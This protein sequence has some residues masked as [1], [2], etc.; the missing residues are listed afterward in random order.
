MRTR[1]GR[2]VCEVVLGLALLVTD[3]CGKGGSST[4][5][6][7]QTPGDFDFGGNDPH[8]VAAFGDSITEGVLELKRRDLGLSTA[9]NY[10]AL[11]QG[12]L[13]SRD[14][15]WVVVNR[16]RGGEESG[17]GAGRLGSVLAIDKPGFV[18]IME[19]TND[20]TDC[21]DASLVASNLR[22][23]VRI[24]KGNSS[25]PILGTIP[26]NFRNHPCAQDVLSQVNV[27]IHS[28]AASEGIVVAEIFDG[29]NDRSLF[30]LS[31]S[32][33][34]L[35]P[36]EQGYSVMADIWFQSMLRALPGGAV[37]ALRR[38]R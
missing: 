25:I 4:G 37:T 10:P 2:L 13:R 29:M 17:A 31:P 28:I 6:S 26:P 27:E 30:G 38:R 23:M 14:G 36:N 8:K 15:G 3:G 22:A 20:A 19:G 12:R 18:L 7:S 35:H 34:P 1:L 11:L 21:R 9:N 24:A 33:D 32:R 5:A 16:G